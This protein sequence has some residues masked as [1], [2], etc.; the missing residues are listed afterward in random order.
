[1]SVRTIVS[2]GLHLWMC[3]ECGCIWHP[4]NG[5]NCPRCEPIKRPKRE[6]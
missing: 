1:M 3:V 5:R 2:N 6:P 4:A